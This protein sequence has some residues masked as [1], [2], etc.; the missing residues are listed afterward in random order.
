M[1]KKRRVIYLVVTYCLMAIFYPLILNAAGNDDDKSV[2]DC[3]S[4]YKK[5]Y[6]ENNYQLIGSCLYPPMDEM[7]LSQGSLVKSK[8]S[9]LEIVKKKWGD[10]FVKERRLSV[11]GLDPFS[12]ILEIEYTNIK[13]EG[14]RASADSVKK[15]ING[16]RNGSQVLAK[17]N[18][19]WYI[20]GKEGLPNYSEQT[21]QQMKYGVNIIRGHAN[22]IHNL[23][24]K[25]IAGKMN[26]DE[27]IE[28]LI[29]AETN[30]Q[31]KIRSLQGR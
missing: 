13:V 12:T 25:V 31:S 7:I 26:K 4:R 18:G 28:N 27:F 22:L 14:N 2:I 15:M 1:N 23:G 19:K 30:F 8:Q 21:L 10:Q 11:L 3:L 20:V 17:A 29:H 5:G 16:N 24:K 9:L 6:E